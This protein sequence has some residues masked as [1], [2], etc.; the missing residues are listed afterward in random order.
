MTEAQ[1]ARPRREEEAASPAVLGWDIGGANLKAVLLATTGQ[2]IQ[3]ISRPFPLWKQPDR[4][5]K[6]LAELAVQFPPAAVWAVTM[7]GELCD[8]FS[9]RREGVSAI[10]EAVEQ[11]V[12][13]GNVWVWTTAG[14]FVTPEVARQ[15]ALRVAS[16]NWHALATAAARQF[17]PYGPAL[18]CDIGSTTTDLIPLFQGRPGPKGWTDEERLRS[19]EL[20]YRGVRRTPLCVLMPEKTCAE[21]FATTLDLFLILG[22]LPPDASDTDTADG[23]PAT[24]PWAYARLARLL[25][26]DSERMHPDAL[27]RFAA[28]LLQRLEEQLID[29]WVQV[30]QQDDR[31]RWPQTILLSGSGEF[32]A[33]RVLRRFLSMYPQRPVP[34]ILSLA[35]QL[36]P[37]LSA[38][39][40]AWAVAELA[41]TFAC[42]GQGWK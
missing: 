22:D 17:A 29:A 33:Q 12:D 30:C 8:C 28:Q 7:T 4:L 34:R 27:L 42:G 6:T 16:A 13:A 31:S 5:A 18:L 3:A 19:G 39:A 38:T 23:R 21:W 41:R 36:G 20:I 9:S 40:P 35:E 26:T 25:G 24:R 11:V 10:L 2:P 14:Q 1:V 32:L 15:E 37:R